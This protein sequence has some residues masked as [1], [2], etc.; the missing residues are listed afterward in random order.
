MSKLNYFLLYFVTFVSILFVSAVTA[1]STYTQ[2]YSGNSYDEG[3]AAFRLP[4]NEIRLLGNTGS[5]GDGNT[6]VWLIALDSSANFLW[7]KY[8]GGTQIELIQEVVMTP[9]GD[10][11]MVGSTTQNTSKSY[12]GSLL[13]SMNILLFLIL[14]F[15][16][17]YVFEPFKYSPYSKLLSINEKY[18][19]EGTPVNTNVESFLF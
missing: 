15:V 18:S 2:V 13:S 10:L 12:Q 8:Y 14:Y 11:F 17:M 1:Q 3:V 19:S 7:H 9:E 16:F 4:N 5:F 6:D